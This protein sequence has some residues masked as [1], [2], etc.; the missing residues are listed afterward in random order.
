MPRISVSLDDGVADAVKAAAGGDGKVS[1]WVANLIRDKLL[2]DAAAAAAEYDR[3]R[4][5]EDAWEVERLAGR[6]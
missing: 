6:A 3:E 2:R 4:A 1:S 5:D